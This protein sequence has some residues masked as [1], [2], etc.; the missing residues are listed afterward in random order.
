MFLSLC[1]GLF[2]SFF[3]KTALVVPFLSIIVLDPFNLT[4]DWNN[5]LLVSYRLE[6]TL[7][8]GLERVWAL[9]YMKGSRR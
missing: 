8:Y 5:T 1:I 7:N 3:L 4:V 2:F 9:G 6:N